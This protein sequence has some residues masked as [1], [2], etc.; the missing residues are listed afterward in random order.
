MESQRALMRL[1][2]FLTQGKRRIILAYRR[3]I[4]QHRKVPFS[5]DSFVHLLS[6]IIFSTGASAKTSIPKPNQILDLFYCIV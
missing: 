6:I 1:T 5:Y 3:V 2:Q 4:Q